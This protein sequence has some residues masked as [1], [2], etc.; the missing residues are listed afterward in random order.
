MSASVHTTRT[1]P[2]AAA[3]G[4][5]SPILDGES[6][7]VAECIIRDVARSLP[8]PGAKNADP[9]WAGGEVGY[10][11]F[12]AYLSRSGLLT[13]QQGKRHRDLMMGHLQSALDRVPAIAG[14]PDLAAGLTGVAWAVNHLINVGALEGDDELGDPLDEALVDCV[15]HRSDSMLCEL[16]TGLSGIGLYALQRR[17]RAAGR[18][19]VRLTVDALKNSAVEHHGLRTWFNHP[20]KLSRYSLQATPQGCYN[21]GLS[22]GVPGAIAFLAK[23]AATGVPGARELASGAAT[24]LFAQQRPY[25]NGSRFTSNFLADPLEDTA[26]S[27]LAWCYGDLGAAAAMLLSARCLRRSD[28]EATA[29]DVARNAARRPVAD[30]GV[31]DAGLCHGAFGNA[32]IFRRLHAATGEPCF[33]AAAL[34]WVQ[35]GFAMRQGGRGLAGCRAWVPARAGEP[36]RD[37]WQADPGLLNGFCGIGLVLLGLIS[38]LEP[39]WDESLLLDIPARVD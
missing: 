18:E 6:C 10:A 23:A 17:H 15:R 14:Q 25:A 21:L 35:A 39:A 33:L 34:R 37:P 26:G 4:V 8:L 3:P 1:N 2:K 36:A 12:N 13:Q 9:T 22:H 7:V 30:S 5:W 32:H 29:L 27:R 28:W 19:L 31:V 11:L 16:L 38:P 20:G 24:W